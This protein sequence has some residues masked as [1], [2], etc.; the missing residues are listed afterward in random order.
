MALVLPNSFCST[1]YIEKHLTN[2]GSTVWHEPYTPWQFATGVDTI[3]CVWK[4]LQVTGALSTR[5]YI[6]VA[7]V[8]PDNPSTLGA[9]NL[10]G[11]YLGTSPP[12][13]SFNNTSV[14]GL[15]GQA[16]WFRLGI[17]YFATTGVAEGDVGLQAC[18]HQ[19]GQLAGIKTVQLQANDAGNQVH[20]LTRWLPQSFVS[21]IKWAP[22]INGLTGAST[23]LQYEFVQQTAPTTIHQPNTAGWAGLGG[24]GGVT[25]SNIEACSTEFAPN[26]TY[27]ADFWIRFGAFARLS[28]G[29]NTLTTATLNATVTVRT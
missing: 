18:W 26:P 29:T 15:T 23:L 20:I 24:Y 28:S 12:E 7:A 16:M 21:K 4:N 22:V 6:E 14:A 19:L 25:N 11:S 5:P 1:P 2:P 10:L 27:T 13:G 17:A 9:P 8:R 3:S